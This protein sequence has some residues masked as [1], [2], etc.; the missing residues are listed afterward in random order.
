LWEVVVK[1]TLL[2][3][4]STAATV[5]DLAIGAIGSIQLQ[6]PLTTT[7]IT[8]IDDHHCCYHTVDNDGH[9]KPAVV[10]CFQWWQR[11]S[12]LMEAAVHGSHGNGGL[13]QWWSL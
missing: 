3:L 6:P 4:L 1:T 12:L 11:Q 5:K 13:C 10:V 7:A 9:Q 8:T 2:P